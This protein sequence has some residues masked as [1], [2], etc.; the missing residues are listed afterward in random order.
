M[1]FVRICTVGCISEYITIT[2]TQLVEIICIR[3]NSQ[4]F[5]LGNTVFEHLGNDRSNDC[6]IGVSVMLGSPKE[7]MGPMSS[8]NIGGP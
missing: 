8:K 2:L 5:F 6:N 7:I 3:F 4:R 1:D